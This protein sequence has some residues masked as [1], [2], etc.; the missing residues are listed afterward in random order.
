MAA[1][2]P[3]RAFEQVVDRQLPADRRKR[4]DRAF[5]C[6]NR[7]AANDP[8]SSRIELSQ[9]RDR[10]LGKAVSEVLTL[11]ISGEASNGSTA[12]VAAGRDTDPECPILAA[13]LEDN[14]G[15]TA[16][17]ASTPNHQYLLRPFSMGGALAPATPT[18]ETS[19]ALG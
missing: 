2:G 7:R 6:H 5:V 19:A 14:G 11:R 13:A 9:R 1:P 16:P 4:L 12:S 10:F 17:T 15:A 8:E 18:P 3:N